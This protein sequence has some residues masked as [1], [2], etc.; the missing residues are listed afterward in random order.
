VSAVIVRGDAR[1]LPLPDSSVDLIVTSPPYFGLR[2]YQDGGRAYIGQIGAESNPAEYVAALL[3]VVRECVR[4]LK[5]TGSL[6]VNL[7]DKFSTG[8]SGQSGMAALG[9]R[10]RGGGHREQ[11]AKIRSRAVDGLPPKTL[12][13]LPWRFALGCTDDLGL[14]LRRDIIWSKTNGL[15]ESV[16]DRCRSSHEYLF[17]LTREPR[18]FAAVDDIREPHSD[19]T[20]R[21]YGP[22]TAARQ[23][24]ANAA[25][26][27]QNGTKNRLTTVGALG[28]LPG[29]VWDLASE[30]FTPPAVSPLD[31]RPLP[32]H[33]AAFPTALV[34]RIILGWSPGGICTECEEGRRPVVDARRIGTGRLWGDQGRG[35]INTLAHRRGE[36]RTARTHSG[37]TCAC[38]DPDAPTRPAVVLDPFGGT[39]TT[40]LVASSLGRTGINVDASHDYA[41]LARWRTTDP[42]QRAKALGVAKP[43]VQVQ[44]QADLFGGAA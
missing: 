35:P 30:P 39:G 5:P 11:K 14:I 23:R 42:G 18:Y 19:H 33:Y 38:P 29:S 34:R 7:G 6:W 43:P 20:L 12:M 13:G 1:A 40:A 24:P 32:E 37:Y 25:G 17:H 9:E 22:G 44:G 4:V 2:V 36:E 15:P 10:Y 21:Y 3:D 8:N 31:G 26:N 27:A 28:R 16:T 41:R